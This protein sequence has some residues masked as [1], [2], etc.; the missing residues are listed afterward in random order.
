MKNG[1]APWGLNCAREQLPEMELALSDAKLAYGGR[2]SASQETK[3]EL[4]GRRNLYAEAVCQ[5]IIWDYRSLPEIYFAGTRSAA[6]AEAGADAETNVGEDMEAEAGVDALEPGG[7]NGGAPE[8]GKTP[9]IAQAGS[10]PGGGRREKPLL[11]GAVRWGDTEFDRISQRFS[12]MIFDENGRHVYISLTYTK[13]EKMTIR[14]LERLEKRMKERKYASIV[15]FGNLYMAEGRLCLYPVE[16]WLQ[17]DE[18]LLEACGQRAGKTKAQPSGI[19]IE[20]EAKIF[21]SGEKAKAKTEA[22]GREGRNSVEAA[23]PGKEVLDVMEQYLKEAKRHLADLFVS[24]IASV[25]EELA[26]RILACSREG[27]ELGLHRAGEALAGI[28]DLL[29]AKRHQ[30]EFSAE[31]L[32]EAWEGLERYF[33]VCEEKVSRDRAYLGLGEGTEAGEG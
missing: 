17:E 22:V 11:L 30:M 9:G 3:G 18:R 16:F 1:P 32:L 31:P 5:R 24:G 4:I 14:L 27:E 25:G 23:L 28:G 20:A 26:E 21:D 19:E 10:N 2:L 13:E 7:A 6:K 29:H 12:W 15:F 8:Q 33:R